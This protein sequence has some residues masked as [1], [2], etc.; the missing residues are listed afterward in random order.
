MNT[1]SVRIDE[2][3]SRQSGCLFLELAENIRTVEGV[4]GAYI[5]QKRASD[6][7]LPEYGRKA[8]EGRLVIAPLCLGHFCE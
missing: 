2:P 1:L 7:I 5:R 6:G 4:L 3:E 8:L